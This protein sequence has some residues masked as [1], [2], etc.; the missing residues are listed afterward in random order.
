MEA[1][2]LVGLL[3]LVVTTIF[4]VPV[5]GMQPYEVLLLSP[6]QESGP[7]AGRS[8]TVSTGSPSSRRGKEPAATPDFMKEFKKKKQRNI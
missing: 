6:L 7:R 8:V 2:E 1:C 4:T 3:A 5:P